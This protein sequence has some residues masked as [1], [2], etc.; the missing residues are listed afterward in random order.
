MDNKKVNIGLGLINESFKNIDDLKALALA[1]VLKAM[2]KSS[3][4]TDYSIRKIIRITG[5]DYKTAKKAI[6]NGI[7]LKYFEIFDHTDGTKRLKVSKIWHKYDSDAIQ[8]CVAKFKD[9]HINLY[10]QDGQDNNKYIFADEINSKKQLPADY[11]DK[12]M[13][14]AIWKFLFKHGKAFE[15]SLCEEYRQLMKNFKIDRDDLD[16]LLRLHRER[17]KG[18]VIHS[19]ADM[20][21]LG[22]SY[23]TILDIFQ[24][25]YNGLTRY[26]IQKLVRMCDS[27][28][29][30]K[31][32]HN[33]IVASEEMDR[34]DCSGPLAK[35]AMANVRKPNI[36]EEGVA[37]VFKYAE[38]CGKA[39]GAR[40]E[41]S[42]YIT[43]K[44]GNLVRD[45][46]ESGFLGKGK[47][48]NKLFVQFGNDFFITCD[49]IRKKER[50]PRLRKLD[51]KNKSKK[52]GDKHKSA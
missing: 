14:A 26:K 40:I 34:K 39:N 29:L 5:F 15:T 18:L 48:K 20:P 52:A 23:D 7:R 36:K 21:R 43:D 24:T 6:A 27:E 46:H 19:L 8:F 31:I 49:I 4:V 16:V 45:L 38:N 11:I 28:G 33:I 22:V 35:E 12:V 37:S 2:F 42:Y 3:I 17:N 25:P 13:Q 41:S 1:I 32:S 47:H 30:L 44:D 51:E 50:S 10:F 9:G